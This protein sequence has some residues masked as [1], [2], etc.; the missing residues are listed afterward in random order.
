MTYLSDLKIDSQ[1]DM[2]DNAQGFLK[3][4]M[5]IETQDKK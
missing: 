3:H 4:D 2:F 1:M 5:P